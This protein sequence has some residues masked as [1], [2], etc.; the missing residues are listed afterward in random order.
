MSCFKSEIVTTF[1]GHSIKLFMIQRAHAVDVATL[2]VND[3]VGDASIVTNVWVSGR[4]RSNGGAG[5]GGIVIY[6]GDV[7]PDFSG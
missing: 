1:P 4:N 3:G 5:G 2:W 7:E 6:I